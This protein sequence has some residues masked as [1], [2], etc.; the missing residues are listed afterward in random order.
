MWHLKKG[1]LKKQEILRTAEFLFC[2]NGYEA[3]GVQEI[4]DALHTSKGSFYHHFV[5]KEALLE[6]ICRARLSADALHCQLPPSGSDPVSE[7]NALLSCV[8]PFTGEK[9]SFLLM[10]LPVFRLNEGI[11]LR[12]FYE[13]EL[14]KI[15]SDPLSEILK[16]GTSYGFFVCRNPAFS[17]DTVLLIVNRLWMKTCDMILERESAG[18]VAD[19]AELLAMIGEYRLAIERILCA[20][21]GSISLIRLSDIL[22]ITEQIH[23]HWRKA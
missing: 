2:R 22:S 16:K 17:A 8:I 18:S 14:I 9:L 20:P 3:T 4:I 7:L 15:Y 19:P 23:L 5:S 11:H 12:C 6:E 21:F 10:L 1:D 13:K